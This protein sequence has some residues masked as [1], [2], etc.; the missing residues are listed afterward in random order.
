MDNNCLDT[1]MS[2][3]EKIFSLCSTIRTECYD[4]I[5]LAES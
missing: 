5:L 3:F 1:G 4:S 2:L